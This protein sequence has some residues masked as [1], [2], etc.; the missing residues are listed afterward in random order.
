MSEEDLRTCQQCAQLRESL[1]PCEAGCGR[2]ICSYCG[3]KCKDCID[4]ETYDRLREEEQEQKRRKRE[5]KK[6]KWE[7][8]RSISD[9]VWRAM[10]WVFGFADGALKRELQ[11]YEGE[12][13]DRESEDIQEMMRARW[14]GL[15]E[16]KKNLYRA[17]K[18]TEMFAAKTVLKV[19][20]AG[21]RMIGQIGH[22]VRRIYDDSSDDEEPSY[23]EEAVEEQSDEELDKESESDD[24]EENADDDWDKEEEDK[25]D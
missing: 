16:W 21:G 20:T 19:G 15:P 23:D 3:P 4:Q 11:Y 6:P 17:K 10:D 7:P 2:E 12:F 22:P 5:A 8:E 1:E 18:K 24:E 14:K 13:E 25:E 9:K